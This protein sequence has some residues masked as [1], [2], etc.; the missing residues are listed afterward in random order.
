MKI[1]IKKIILILFFLFTLFWMKNTFA[2]EVLSNSFNDD[3]NW[4]YVPLHNDDYSTPYI[5]SALNS[6]STAIWLY[7]LSYTGTSQRI[8]YWWYQSTFLLSYKNF[9]S[10]VPTSFSNGSR[11]ERTWGFIYDL[12]Y[13]NILYNQYFYSDTSYCS[14]VQCFTSQ[15]FVDN[16]LVIKFPLSTS[17]FFQWKK[18]VNWEF[19][20][21]SGLIPSSLFGWWRAWWWNPA[22]PVQYYATNNY[23]FWFD[24]TNK[25]IKYRKYINAGT[26][27]TSVDWEIDYNI[28]WLTWTNMWFQKIVELWND[29]FEI[30]LTYVKT[31][32]WT[33]YIIN[34][35]TN[36]ILFDD[37]FQTYLWNP[38]LTIQTNISLY[39]NSN[40]YSIVYPYYRDWLIWK[41]YIK[42]NWTNNIYY[43]GNIV[44]PPQKVW[45]CQDYTSSIPS[46]TNEEKY[47]LQWQTFTNS[48][49]IQNTVSWK[50]TYWFWFNKNS[51]G[52][53]SFLNYFISNLDNFNDVKFYNSANVE[54]TSTGGIL[55]SFTNS[56]YYLLDNYFFAKWTVNDPGIY[57]NTFNKF[58]KINVKSTDVYAYRLYRKVEWEWTLILKNCITNTVCDISQVSS[59]LWY[60]SYD[61]ILIVPFST[62]WYVKFTDYKINDIEIY[63]YTSEYVTYPVCY[64]EDW[65]I[66][67]NWQEFTPEEWEEYKENEI[68][69]WEA[70]PTAYCNEL[71][72]FQYIKDPV[73]LSS[74]LSTWFQKNIWTSP[75]YQYFMKFLNFISYKIEPSTQISIFFFDANLVW[76]NE[77]KL[78]LDPE[79]LNFEN[80]WN[81]EPDFETDNGKIL[82]YT[83]KW[84]F[85]IFFYVLIFIFIF[86][87]FF[88]HN[89]IFSWFL[90]VIK[91]AFPNL[92]DFNFKEKMNF[93]S[94]IALIPLI[95]VFL[96]L[97]NTFLLEYI[98]IFKNTFTQVFNILGLI[99]DTLYWVFT[100]DFWAF[101]IFFNIVNTYLTWAFIIALFAI[102]L[103]KYW[104][105]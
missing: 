81:Y 12:N 53:G 62:S 38:L 56:W 65:S 79:N 3:I 43:D 47:N 17:P 22:N 39:R 50:N 77:Y 103:I 28:F 40:V 19:V 13:K 6:S 59:T 100:S 34:T 68:K 49:F 55:Q 97:F 98:L 10:A 102:I 18:E 5:L 63:S 87:V 29:K 71:N 93:I 32:Y 64:Y 84:L 70:K 48:W 83:I 78:N 51:N 26:S 36:T 35:Q 42:N 23:V 72:F 8:F 80:Y 33:S 7:N 20:A 60:N 61:E 52:T 58:Q 89:F 99:F 90:K 74:W 16:W 9:I 21:Y 75:A 66:D 73:C 94:Y 11:T 25:K 31:G 76:F 105:F 85:I 69:N 24:Y 46:L 67:V 88:V 95:T 45:V 1:Q 30:N 91:M 96:F 54:Q 57:L 86:L 92:L 44:P 4:V 15:F 41:Y 27:I 37:W 104:R 14:W 2:D 101:I 82:L